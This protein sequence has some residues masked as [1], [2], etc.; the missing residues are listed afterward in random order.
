MKIA[1]AFFDT[2]ETDAEVSQPGSAS[3]FVTAMIEPDPNAEQGKAVRKGTTNMYLF[4]NPLLLRGLPKVVFI[5]GF[6]GWG[7]ITGCPP[8]KEG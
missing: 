1:G 3:I 6:V 5:P 8:G 4:P 2:S 7:G